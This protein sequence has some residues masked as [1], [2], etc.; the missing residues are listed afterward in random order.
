MTIQPT[1]PSHALAVSQLVNS[2]STR[3]LSDFAAEARMDG[4]SLRDALDRY[5]IDYAWH[6]LNSDRLQQETLTVLEARLKC[7]ANDEQRACVAD[8]L[9]A[10]ADAQA[11]D[12]LMSFDNDVAELLAERLCAQWADRAAA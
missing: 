6:V 3:T 4:E 12:L 7:A 8:I 11:P 9:K 1:T 10:A 5:E 2:L